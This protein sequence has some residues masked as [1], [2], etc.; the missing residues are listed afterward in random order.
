MSERIKQDLSIGSNLKRL[1]KQSGLSQEQV[2]AK[3]Q[4]MGI[5]VSREMLSQMELGHYN[6]RVSVLLALKQIYNA[7]FDDFFEGISL[8]DS[9]Q[10]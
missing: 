6:I 2:A 8:C 5:S 9:I 10:T 4:L 1:R 3:L 7:S